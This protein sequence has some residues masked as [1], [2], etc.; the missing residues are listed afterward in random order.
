MTHINDD[1]LDRGLLT[2]VLKYNA[3]HVIQDI[4]K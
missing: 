2:Q 3:T 4:E 1:S